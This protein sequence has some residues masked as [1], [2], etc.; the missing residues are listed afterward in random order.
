M[1]LTWTAADWCKRVLAV[2][3]IERVW[4]RKQ[5]MRHATELNQMNGN[6]S[7][8]LERINEFSTFRPRDHY[9]V[10]A[11]RE[12]HC[13]IC[14]RLIWSRGISACVQCKE[15]EFAVCS[16]CCKDMNEVMIRH[17]DRNL[18]EEFGYLY[19]RCP[20]CFSA[21]AIFGP[22]RHCTFRHDGHF[23]L[24]Q[25]EFQRAVSGEF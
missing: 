9:F 21:G 11:G 12:I 16:I 2:H 24:R 23:F 7:I 20:R 6:F 5:A 10:M 18:E 22:C 19:P 3:R 1:D 25:D 8:E 13:E 17:A 15:C 14:N 4:F